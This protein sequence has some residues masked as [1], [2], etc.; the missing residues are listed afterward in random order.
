[1]SLSWLWVAGYA[2]NWIEEIYEDSDN[3][4]NEDFQLMMGK[5]MRSGR[6]GRTMRP[7]ET[8]FYGKLWTMQ[9]IAIPCTIADL[10][11]CTLMF[12]TLCTYMYEQHLLLV[13][14][15]CPNSRLLRSKCVPKLCCASRILFCRHHL[16]P[17]PQHCIPSSSFRSLYIKISIWILAKVIRNHKHF[18]TICVLVKLCI[19]FDRMVSRQ[20]GPTTCVSTVPTC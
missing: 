10:A 13:N 16:V 15:E 1:M 8:T 4:Y 6:I 11:S 12:V 19:C 17:I 9:E 18:T 2:Y 3:D 20:P 14:L 7:K 5:I